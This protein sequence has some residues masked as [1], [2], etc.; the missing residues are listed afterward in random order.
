MK[1]LKAQPSNE[2]EINLVDVKFLS[3]YFSN[4][5]TWGQESLPSGIG[6]GLC[7]SVFEPQHSIR[8][9][10]GWKDQEIKKGRDD[11]IT[12]WKHL[13]HLLLGQTN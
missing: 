8:Q 5:K 11:V 1:K 3:S 2:A 12:K 6:G 13:V 9:M 10:D 7:S 4:S